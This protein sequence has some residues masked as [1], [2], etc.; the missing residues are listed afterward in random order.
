MRRRDWDH[1]FSEYD[2]RAVLE[3]QLSAINDKVLGVPKERFAAD[4]DE[5]IAAVIASEL[6]VEPLELEENEISVDASD[7]KVD[8]SREFDR[9]ISDR[10]RP[11]YIDG[12][13]VSY[14][15]PFRGEKEL[16]KC[17]GSQFT[18]N[19]PR[20]V[21]G[22]GELV[23]PYQV[24]GRDLA[25]TKSNFE[26]DLQTVKQWIPW[27]NEPV[28]QYNATLEESVRQRVAQRRSELEKSAS[29]LGALG[30]KIRSSGQQTGE[31]TPQREPVESRRK[32]N[33][34]KAARQYDVALS[35]AGEDREYVARVAER[36]KAL[37]VSV[38]YDDFE[39]I[40]LWGKDLTTHLADV[41]GKQSRFVVIFASK[42]Y[43]AKAW[44][45]HERAVALSRQFAG[46]RDRVL[47]VRFDNTE[48]PGMPSSVSY[49]D[50]RVLSP[51]KLAELIR[52][53]VDTEER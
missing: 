3:H 44:P 17:R 40:N 9:A 14:H 46:D 15:V 4:S 42:H 27:I 11:F 35:F 2:L 45:N 21:I 47:P 31:A 28:A 49:L 22:Q 8:V 6:I 38:F 48:V 16:L 39:K 41:Y 24:A 12:I 53:K 26:R 32:R 19:P 18:F 1:L 43:A 20:A 52:Q 33:R 5:Q 37:N 10:S 23:F 36:L 51:D 7:V 13:E 50:L 34:A 25:S 30:F 29:D